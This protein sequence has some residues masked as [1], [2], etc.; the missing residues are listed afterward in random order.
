MQ[1]YSLLHPQSAR[2]TP[3]DTQTVHAFLQ[4]DERLYCIE[5]TPQRTF[6]VYWGDPAYDA[7]PLGTICFGD[8]ELQEPNTLLVST[9]SDTRMQVLLDLLRPLQLSAPQMQFDTPPTPPKELRR[10]P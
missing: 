7:P 8:L 2:F 5:K 3:V 6:W 1:G 10:R 9:L 4:A